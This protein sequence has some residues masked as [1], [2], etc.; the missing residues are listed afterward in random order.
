M[1]P[2]FG[3]SR[4]PVIRYAEPPDY[5]LLTTFSCLVVAGC[6]WEEEVDSLVRAIGGS[7]PCAEI[8]V[9]VALDPLTDELA[10]VYAFRHDIPLEENGAMHAD[11]TA[12]VVLGVATGYRGSSCALDL[13]PFKGLGAYMLDDCVAEVRAWAHPHKRRLWAFV[14]RE[15]DRCHRMATNHGGRLSADLPSMGYGIWSAIV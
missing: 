6:W 5:G 14:A 4:R 9:R 3:R 13:G 8:S 10:G 12:I 15:N 7:G 1:S 11:A 2:R